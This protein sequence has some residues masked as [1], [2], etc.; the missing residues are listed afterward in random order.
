MPSPKKEASIS[1]DTKKPRPQE[2]GSCGRENSNTIR[3]D[4]FTSSRL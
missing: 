1:I 3:G 4:T 2:Q